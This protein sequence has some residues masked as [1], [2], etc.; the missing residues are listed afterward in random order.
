M[1]AKAAPTQEAASV[2][3]AGRIKSLQDHHLF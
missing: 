1:L 3:L 2:N